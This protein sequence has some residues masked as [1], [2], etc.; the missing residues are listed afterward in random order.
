MIVDYQL[1]QN[2]Y[3]DS[4]F[5]Q[6]R[7]ERMGPQEEGS[8]YV[9][10]GAYCGEHNTNAA[11]EKNIRLITTALTGTEV[12]DIYADFEFSEEG[13]RPALPY[14]QRNRDS[15]ICFEEKISC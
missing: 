2:I 3:S 13:N 5:L 1:E 14:P 9:T 10:D 11:K 7:L 15:T 12:P 8:L 6:D 4:A